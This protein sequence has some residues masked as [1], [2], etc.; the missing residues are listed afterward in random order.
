MKIL[1]VG[2]GGREHAL[3]R[4]IKNSSLVSAVYAWPGNAGHFLDAHSVDVKSGDYTSLVSWAQ[5]AHIDLVVIGPEVELVHGLA[6]MFRHIGILVFGP[7]KRAAQLEGSKVFAKKFMQEYGVP[8]ARAEVVSD[9]AGT[10]SAAQKFSAPYVLKADGLAAG[11]GVFICETL[12]ELQAAAQDI[13]VRRKLGEA[14]AQALLEEFQPG[15][16]ISVLVL[17]NGWDFQ[18]LPFSRDHKRLLEGDR[19]PNTGG[20]GVVGPVKL[21]SRLTEK[22]VSEVVKPSVLGLA[23]RDFVFRGVLFIGVML[24]DAGPRVLEYNV[25]FGDPETQVVLPL[26]DGD[27]ALVLKTLAEG[28]LIPLNW[29]DDRAVACVVMAAEGYPDAP[30]KGVKIDGDLSSHIADDSYVLHAGT[31]VHGTDFLVNGGRVLNVMGVG[32]D[33][34][35]ALKAAYGRVEKISWPGCQFRRDIGVSI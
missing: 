30:V 20:M 2:S 25:R 5:S 32:V 34:R 29:H 26:L 15:Q 23:R 18:V 27:W 3:I 9:V 10:M 11:K 28:Q 35:S 7:E 14:G 16:E 1:V 31:S 8:T 17:T 12:D 24:T 22:I 6:D 19:G 13:F 33:L 21:D 4:E